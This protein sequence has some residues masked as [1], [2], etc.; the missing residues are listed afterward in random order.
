MLWPA[1]PMSTLVTEPIGQDKDGNDVYLK[2][3]WP[4]AEEILE[5]IQRSIQPEMFTEEYETSVNGQRTL[6]CHRRFRW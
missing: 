4:T 2:E 5:T 3:I 1:A 6:E